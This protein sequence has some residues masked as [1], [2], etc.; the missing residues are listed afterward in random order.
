ME[1][2]T[3][4]IQTLMIALVLSLGVAGA[5]VSDAIV[6]D[7]AFCTIPDPKTGMTCSEV[8]ENPEQDVYYIVD[9]AYIDDAELFAMAHQDPET[10]RWNIAHTAFILKFDASELP[11]NLF[12]GGQALHDPKS[13][14]EMK[15]VLT[16]A[17]WSDEENIVKE[18]PKKLFADP[19]SGPTGGEQ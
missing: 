3:P 9:G 18:D 8:S 1:N 16:S 11:R 12:G 19:N 6:L 2:N 7:T 4:T 5:A 10:V 17:E 14:T 15:E 13:N